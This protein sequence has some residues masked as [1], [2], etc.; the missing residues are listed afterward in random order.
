MED[1]GTRK[2]LLNTKIE[3]N[4]DGSIK[5]NV[6]IVPILEPCDKKFL[7]YETSIVNIYQ[8]VV[9]ILNESASEYYNM[10]MALKENSHN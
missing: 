6:V 2:K 10:K 4:L 3:P 8:S 5:N 7:T 1:Y 9:S